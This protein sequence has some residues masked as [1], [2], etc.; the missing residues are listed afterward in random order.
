M[1]QQE[2]IKHYGYEHQLIKLLEELKELEDVI[3]NCPTHEEHLQEEMAD[4]LNLIEQIMAYKDWVA[5]ICEIKEYKINRQLKRIEL[6][7]NK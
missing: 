7:K 4:V 3:L 2:I 5:D 6:E 1:Q